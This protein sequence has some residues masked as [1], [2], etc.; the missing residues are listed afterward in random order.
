MSLEIDVMLGGGRD[1][2]SSRADGRDLYEEAR[3]FLNYTTVG[4]YA[5]DP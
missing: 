5:Y 3:T 4:N 2:F 1:A